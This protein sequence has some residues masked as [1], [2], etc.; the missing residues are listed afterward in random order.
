MMQIYCL[1]TCIITIFSNIS[2]ELIF[3]LD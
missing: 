1:L 3:S 2:A